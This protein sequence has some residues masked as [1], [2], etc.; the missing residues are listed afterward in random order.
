M[1]VKNVRLIF[2]ITLETDWEGAYHRHSTDEKAEAP[3]DKGDRDSTSQASARASFLILEGQAACQP[4]LENLAG[5]LR[6]RASQAFGERKP[7]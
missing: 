5:N 3:G 7:G 4:V 6:V 2:L 1:I